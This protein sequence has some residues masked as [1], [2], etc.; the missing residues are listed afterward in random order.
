MLV[1][2]ADPGRDRVARGTEVDAF[3]VD[4]DLAFLGL[5][6]AGEHVHQRALARAVLAEQRMYFALVQVEIHMI[7]GKD[8]W[9]ALDDAPHFDCQWGVGHGE[10]L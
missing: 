3:A 8:A 5:V 2:H 9:E 1:N 6:H 4:A 7:V 10:P